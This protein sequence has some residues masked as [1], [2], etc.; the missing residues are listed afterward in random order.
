MDPI[1]ILVLLIFLILVLVAAIVPSQQRK[2]AEKAGITQ[3]EEEA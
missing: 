3:A 2:R 1:A